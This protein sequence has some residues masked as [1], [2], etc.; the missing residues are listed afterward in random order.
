LRID[1]KKHKVAIVLIAVVL[2]LIFVSS[3]SAFTFPINPPSKLRL[4]PAPVASFTV[5]DP[6]IYNDG[7]YAQ[8]EMIDFTDTSSSVIV[9]WEWSFGDGQFSTLQNP[10]HSYVDYPNPPA[11]YKIYTVTLRVTNSLG[12]TSSTAKQVRIAFIY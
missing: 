5:S 2:A 12:F 7:S 4:P 1:S 10:K 11:Y 8:G 3:A 9:K 6:Q